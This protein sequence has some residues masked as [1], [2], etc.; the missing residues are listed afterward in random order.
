MAIETNGA[1]WWRLHGLTITI[2]VLMAS[3]QE[4]LTRK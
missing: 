4:I 3:P 1:I 2:Y